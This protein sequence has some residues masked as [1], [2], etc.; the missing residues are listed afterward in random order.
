MKPALL[1]IIAGL[2]VV[3]MAG[4]Y[5]SDSIATS[6][7][8]A[9][10]NSDKIGMLGHVE[11]VLIDSNGMTK[12]Y[13]QTDNFVTDMGAACTASILFDQ[14]ETLSPCDTTGSAVNEFLHIAV[15]DSQP[16]ST[17]TTRTGLVN[18]IGNRRTDTNAELASN[19][20]AGTASATIATENPFTFGSGNNTNNIFEAGLFDETTG[21]N[22]F[23]I[24]NA[25]SGANPGIDVN[26]GDE[27]S[28]TWT[29]T[30]G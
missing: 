13:Y 16:S 11:Y 20:G 9:S 15:G 6:L 26:D 24:Q 19:S 22:A 10:P 17:D 21:G 29:I 7:T 2:S 25:T 14:D 27:L 12:A 1:A 5:A 3:S 4:I 28:V 8:V 18:E 23:A 30:V